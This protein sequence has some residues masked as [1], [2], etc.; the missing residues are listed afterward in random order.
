[1][2]QTAPGRK[3]ASIVAVDVAGYSRRTEKDEAAAIKAVAGLR[4]RIAASAAAH[5][6][7]VFNTAGDGFML[8][9][10]TASGALAAAS[11]VSDRRE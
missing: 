10:P 5:G 4:E 11:S 3:L 2:D 8:E 9:F 1:M 6:G 7:R